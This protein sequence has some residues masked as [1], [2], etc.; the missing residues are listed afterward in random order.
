[1]SIKPKPKAEPSDTI[2]ARIPK[3][4]RIL[5]KIKLGETTNESDLIRQ[6]LEQFVS[7]N[8]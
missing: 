3:R 6:L 8:D 5:V 2:S 4:L 7:K 1:M